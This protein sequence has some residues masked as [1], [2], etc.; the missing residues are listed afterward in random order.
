MDIEENIEELVSRK[1][2]LYR[3]REI[4]GSIFG[5]YDLLFQDLPQAL[6]EKGELEAK[7]KAFK[8]ANWPNLKL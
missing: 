7:A 1:R 4:K 6:G 2:H 5:T 8:N 3:A